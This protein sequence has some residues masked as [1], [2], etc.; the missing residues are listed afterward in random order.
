MSAHQ[1]GGRTE[2]RQLRDRIVRILVNL[3]G[4]AGAALFA[5]A[6]LQYYMH[7]HRLIGGVFFIEQARFLAAFLVPPPPPAAAWH[8]GGRL[9]AARGT[10]GGGLPRPDGAHPAC[11]GRTR[12]R[13]ARTGP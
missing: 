7:T 8:L 5:Q 11:G 4:A 10:L 13:P 1:R 2:W 6:S 9:L 3:L 12:P